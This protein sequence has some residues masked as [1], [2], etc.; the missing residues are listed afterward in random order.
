MDREPQ[1][2]HPDWCDPTLCTASE[3]WKSHR[4]APRR[5]E[6]RASGDVDVYVQLT[7][8]AWDPVAEAPASV[9]VALTR[10]DLGS[11]ET[12]LLDQRTVRE[13]HSI[14]GD[15]LATMQRDC[16]IAASVTPAT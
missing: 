16:K 8:V 13:F 15:M 9:E 7:S 14:L 11:V 6:H 1:I 12:N 2:A 3:W 5:I 10:S 4:S